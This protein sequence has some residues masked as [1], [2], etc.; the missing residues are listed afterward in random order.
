[1]SKLA[2]GTRFEN[3]LLATSGGV[4]TLTINRPPYNVIDIKT[5]S[6]M[7]QALDLVEQD[8]SVKV[9]VVNAAGTKAF[10]AGVDVKD[11]TPELVDAMMTSFDALCHRLTAFVKVTLSAVDGLCL[12]GGC[13]VAVSCDLVLATDR[14]QF[15]QPEI[16][17]GVFPPVAVALFPRLMS[18]KKAL[19]LVLTGDPIGAQEAAQLGLVN[20]VVAP[21]ALET[22][23]RAMLERLTTKSGALLTI[24]KRAMRLGRDRSYGEALMEIERIYLKELMSTED[25]L[26]GL[27][28][29]M[30][31]RSP[32]WR[33]R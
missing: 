18:A 17:V 7:H 16:K 2:Y 32:V 11:H 26:E 25:A 19:E 10:S 15:G 14:A 3:I 27:K 20:K 28:A 23:V 29:Y 1:M 33:D 8:D 4:A 9:L 22:E 24:T 21:D 31:K 13:E 6:E 12:G 30:E 5:M